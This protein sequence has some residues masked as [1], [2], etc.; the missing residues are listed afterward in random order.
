VDVGARELLIERNLV[1]R[2]R[3]RKEKATKSHQ[4]R[5]IALDQATMAILAE[6]RQRCQ[7]RATAARTSLRAA[8]L[9][10]QYLN[11]PGQVQPDQD[12]TPQQR[13]GS[14]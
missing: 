5:R 7:Q 13:A 12:E 11:R 2:G 10:G 8:E 6:H 4:A 3:Q 14:D 1:Q 9:L